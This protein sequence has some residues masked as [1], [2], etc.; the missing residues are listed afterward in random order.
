MYLDTDLKFQAIFI[1]ISP[2]HRPQR[3][4]WRVGLGN[5]LSRG[6]EGILF[7]LEDVCGSIVVPMR[8]PSA[9]QLGLLYNS[10]KVI[11]A[12]NCQF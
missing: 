12:D 5:R 4:D 7:N 11:S 2:A 8:E 6:P 9:K 10:T 1:V 3:A